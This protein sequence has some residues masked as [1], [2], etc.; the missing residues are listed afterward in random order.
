M[1]TQEAVDHYGG[2]K[3]LAHALNI[4]PQAIKNWGERPPRGRQFE[5]YVLTNR[6]LKIDEEFVN[7]TASQSI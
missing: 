6:E 4:Y 5:L 3:Q 2:I 1:T 7:G